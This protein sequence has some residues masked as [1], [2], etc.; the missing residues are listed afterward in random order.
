VSSSD[1]FC[2]VCG[3]F[4]DISHRK[5]FSPLLKKAYE[6]Y[7]DS[8]VA[9]GKTWESRFICLTC[10]MNLG[11]WIRKAKKNKHMAFLHKTR[12]VVKYPDVSSISKPIPH[13]PVT[14]PV[15]IP[16]WVAF[17]SVVINFLGN[18]KTADCVCCEAL[19]SDS[20]AATCL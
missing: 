7:F 20:W 13:D 12:S 11:G 15:P 19:H 1:L 8:K 9:I 16:A 10:S 6:L 3:Y 14:C 2:Y 18:N 5:T 17:K 4:T